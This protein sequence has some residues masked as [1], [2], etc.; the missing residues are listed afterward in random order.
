MLIYDKREKDEV[1]LFWLFIYLFF[2]VKEVYL[3]DD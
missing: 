2:H 3:I 1:D